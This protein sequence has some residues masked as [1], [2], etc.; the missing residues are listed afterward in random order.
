M[1][2]QV[3]LAKSYVVSLIYSWLQEPSRKYFCSQGDMEHSGHGPFSIPKS[4]RRK[5]QQ[6]RAEPGNLDPQPKFPILWL[7]KNLLKRT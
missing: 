7:K 1:K 5:G 2:K 3:M 6:K 4:A